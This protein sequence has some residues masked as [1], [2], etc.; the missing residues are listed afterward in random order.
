M[1]V[2]K[3]KFIDKIID[4]INSTSYGLTFGIHSRIVDFT[5]YVCSRINAGN[6]YINR[7]ITGAIVET[8]PFG[9]MNLSG[10]GFKA[11]GPNYIKKFVN[12]VTITD[13]VTAIGG[14]V[15]LLV[16]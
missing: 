6:I 4:E 2:F 7:T 11:G 12:E 3:R 13:N 16:E 1:R 14:N 10:T 15:E 8:H 9:G 5:D